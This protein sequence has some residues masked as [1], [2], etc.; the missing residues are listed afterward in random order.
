MKHK[1]GLVKQG[2]LN[3]IWQKVLFIIYWT[4]QKKVNVNV[5][6]RVYRYQSVQILPS[7]GK[8]ITPKEKIL[9]VS[10]EHPMME[11]SSIDASVHERRLYDWALNSYIFAS[12]SLSKDDRTKSSNLLICISFHWQ[13]LFIVKCDFLSWHVKFFILLRHILLT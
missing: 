2:S 6:G 4:N 9:L 10:I 7:S 13:G 3:N 1:R 12:I 5:N 11:E 8:F